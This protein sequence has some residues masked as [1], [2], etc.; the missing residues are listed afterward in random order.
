MREPAAS[1]GRTFRCPESPEVAVFLNIPGIGHLRPENGMPQ[2]RGENV[3]II[4]LKDATHSFW[5]ATYSN[6]TIT[7]R[8]VTGYQSAIRSASRSTT[9]G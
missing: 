9:S 1:I 6:S 4:G 5:N 7:R 3:T 2:E 8:S